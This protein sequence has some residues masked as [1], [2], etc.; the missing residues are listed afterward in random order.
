MA[1]ARS[2]GSSQSKVSSSVPPQPLEW[3]ASIQVRGRSYRWAS[4]ECTRA[5][6]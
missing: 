5:S 4:E 3:N 2:Q 1:P 6:P